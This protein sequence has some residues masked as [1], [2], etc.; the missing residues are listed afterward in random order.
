MGLRDLQ[1]NWHALGTVDP[2]WA[3]LAHP[4]HRGNKWERDEFFATGRDQVREVLAILE[5]VR[6]MPQRRDVALDFGTGAG[7][8]AIALA[9]T[10]DRV[11]GVDI[12]PSMIELATEVNP[13][14]HRIS[15]VLNERP[16][17]AFAGD[18]SVDFVLSIVVLQHM[19]NGLKTGYLREFLRVLR[20]GGIAAFT[21]PS[22]ADHS[23]V[24]LL[25]RLPNPVQNVYRRRRYGYHSVMEM[26]L[27][28][29]RRVEQVLRT[30]GAEIV[31]VEEEPMA[32]PPFTSYLYVIRRPESAPTPDGYP[33]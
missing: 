24:G 1:R 32:G 6:G 14:P 16:D 4:Q 30:A 31:H 26:H 19:A 3:I 27:M 25:R 5:R 8:L 10:F 17:L 7:R 13:A 12:A 9:D 2:Y 18:A 15:Y 20:P 29:R 33:T 21:I 22:H 23:P 28:K 11:V